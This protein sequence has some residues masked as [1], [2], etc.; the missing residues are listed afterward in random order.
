M[1]TNLNGIRLQYVDLGSGPVI[2]LL[3][4][5]PLSGTMWRHQLTRLG[6]RYRLIVPDLRGFGATDAPP[7]PVSMDQYADD[8]AALLA[9][10][11]V[12]R[13]AVVGLSMGGYIAFALWRRHA[14]RVA[15]LV[16]ADT[17]A[18]ADGDEARAARETNARLAE[19]AGVGAVADK[20]IPGLIAPDAPQALRDELRAIIT[21]NSADGVA[22]ALRGMALRPDSTPDLAR[23]N[24]P[25]LAIV[26]ER[27]G[28]TPPAEAQR[29][30]DGVAAGLGELAVIPGVGHLSALEAPEAFSAA[31][32]RFLD[33]VGS[34]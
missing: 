13:A 4:A 8:A 34:W 27:D 14:E 23:I 24:V 32:E 31:L 10:L 21:A 17:K 20:L 3:H 18:G 9:H 15:A 29:I 25:T 11:G 22:G 26:G 1:E 33:R 12:A 5:F 16:L 2:L 30:V 28:L 19:E 6:G 7:G